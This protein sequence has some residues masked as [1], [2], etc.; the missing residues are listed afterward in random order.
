MIRTDD[1]NVLAL[2]GL[3]RCAIKQEKPENLP[4]FSADKLFSLAK[5]QQV[6]NLILPVLQSSNLLS[7][8]QEKEW[9]NYYLTELERTIVV[10][11]EREAVC[12][13]LDAAGVKYMF[14]KGLILRD[15]YPQSIM[16]Q[17]SDNDFMYDESMWK[18]LFRIMKSHGFHLANSI[19]NSDDF[20]KEPYC[21]FEFHRQLFY[22]KDEFCPQ[23]NPFENATPEGN[24]T[25][26]YNMTAED[27]F[28]YTLAHMYKHY[29]KNE[30]CGIRFACD[31][32]L[33]KEKE[34]NLDFGYISSTIER[35]GITDFYNKVMNII[36]AVFDDGELSDAEQ[37]LLNTMLGG[38]IYG[39]LKGVDY[40]KE[41]E[42]HGGRAGYLLHRLFPPKSFMK[43]TYRQLEE[44]P[45]LLGWYYIYRIFDKS[46]HS[47]ENLRSDLKGTF[48]K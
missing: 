19:E 47:R 38:G 36:S 29:Y 34:Q 11:N 1:N 3:V 24:G 7:D 4:D 35:F 43:E 23:F 28:V 14:T 9:K 16:R 12:S 15:Y 13:D 20:Y 21:S 45:Y 40:E 5:K 17:M 26:K 22:D 18:E 30:S 48:K 32:Y 2:L 25:M 37:E 42:A 39:N 10:N 46:L 31:L 41:L 6:Y 33:I 8:E 44:K 27:N